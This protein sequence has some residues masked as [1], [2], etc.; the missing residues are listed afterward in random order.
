M[1]TLDSYYINRGTCA[2]IPIDKELSHVY[3]IDNSYVIEKSVKEIIDDSCKYYGCSYK[4]RCDG[5]RRILNMNY[6]L[7]IVIEEYNIVGS[8]TNVIKSTQPSSLT[9]GNPGKSVIRDTQKMSI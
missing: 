7:P 2:I 3:E 6:K 9:I 8:G 4:G 1:K 5:S